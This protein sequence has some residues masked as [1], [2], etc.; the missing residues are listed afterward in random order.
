MSETLPTKFKNGDSRCPGA[1]ECE[2]CWVLLPFPLGHHTQGGSRVPRGFQA[3]SESPWS[4][5]FPRTV[6]RRET[7]VSLRWESG[8]VGLSPDAQANQPEVCTD[9]LGREKEIRR[10]GRKGCFGS[11]SSLPSVRGGVL[12][13][14]I[15]PLWGIKIRFLILSMRLCPEDFIWD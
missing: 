12:T 8:G 5:S 4:L 6:R 14:Q 9:A 10:G 2:M 3:V 1:C 15:H 7:A 13:R 11:T